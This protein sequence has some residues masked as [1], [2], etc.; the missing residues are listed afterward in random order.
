MKWKLRRLHPS[1]LH[2]GQLLLRRNLRLLRGR[3]GAAA[4]SLLGLRQ[5]EAVQLL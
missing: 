3:Q 2:L 4:G 1:F 5:E